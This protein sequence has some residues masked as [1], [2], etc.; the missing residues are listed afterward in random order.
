[1]VIDWDGNDVPAKVTVKLSNKKFKGIAGYHEMPRF[2]QNVVNK[3]YFPETQ[4][5]V[6]IDEKGKVFSLDLKTWNLAVSDANDLQC[7]DD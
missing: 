5:W 3:K 6:F 1:L 7:I 2:N 4:K